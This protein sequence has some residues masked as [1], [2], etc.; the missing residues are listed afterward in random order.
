MWSK[1]SEATQ[2]PTVPGPRRGDDGGDPEATAGRQSL[3]ELV[4]GAG[5]RGR[6]DHVVEQA[7]VLIVVEDEAVLRRP[8]GFDAIASIFDATKSAP[9]AGRWS[10]CSDW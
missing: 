8:L 7:V 5:G 9:A 3:D 6:R 1:G 10:G 4:R 2:P